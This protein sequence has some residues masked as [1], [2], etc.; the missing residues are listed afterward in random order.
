MNVTLANHGAHRL[1]YNLCGCGVERRT[2]EGWIAVAAVDE[3][4]DCE[5]VLLEL[6]VGSR[7]GA[8]FHL[9]RNI[10]DGEYRFALHGEWLPYFLFG[11]P[12]GH[13]HNSTLAT[14]PF[15]VMSAAPKG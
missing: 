6:R 14:K 3:A 5:L 13:G 15:H 2:S 9:R 8:T 7:T 4:N 12:V 11:R 10:A 1:G